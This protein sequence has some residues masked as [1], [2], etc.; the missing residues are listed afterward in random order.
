[1]GLVKSAW[2][3]GTKLKSVWERSRWDGIYCEYLCNIFHPRQLIQRC[4]IWRCTFYRSKVFSCCLFFS[5]SHATYFSSVFNLIFISYLSF[6]CPLFIHYI[7]SYFYTIFIL[8][9]SYIYLIFILYLSYIHL[10]FTLYLSYIYFIFI[11][12]LSYISRL[13]F[14]GRLDWLD[15][16]SICL[17]WFSHVENSF[18]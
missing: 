9:L 2:L 18:P 16:I 1:M 17:V 13:S 11:L 10:I 12:H 4:A 14:I 8:H 3:W 6:I 7:L 15:L 5:T